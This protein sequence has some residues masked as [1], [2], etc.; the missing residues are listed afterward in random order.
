MRATT[1]DTNLDK[2]ILTLHQNLPVLANRYKVISLA[3]FGSYARG[4]ATPGSDL[5]ILVEFAEVPTLFEFVRL[6]RSLSELVGTKVDLVMKSGL[7]PT[8]GRYILAEAVPI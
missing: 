2:I 1:Q 8:I 5:D 6:Q 4:E 3:V 7:K